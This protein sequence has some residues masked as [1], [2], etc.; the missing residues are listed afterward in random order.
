MDNL[1]GSD[2]TKGVV[3]KQVLTLAIPV[4]IGM[5]LTMGYGIINM[6]WIG[7]FLG[8]EA[9]AAASVGF[10]IILMLVSIASGSTMAVTVLVS[11]SYGNKN[12]DM[13]QKISGTALTFFSLVALVLT[14]AGLLFK[15]SIL[16]LM[17]TPENIFSGASDYLAF[18]LIGFLVTYV[19]SVFTAM[20]NGIGDTKTPSILLFISTGLNAV[21]DPLFIKIFGLNGA[22][23]ASLISG[24][25]CVTAAAIYLRKK[26]P[27]FN[28]KLASIKINLKVL[29]DILKIGVPSVIQDGLT[30]IAMIFITGIVNGFGTDATAAFGAASKV[31]YLII[32]PSIALLTAMSVY[33]GQNLGANKIERVKSAFKT[34]IIL[35]IGV[36]VVITSLVILLPEVFLKTMVQDENVL[37]IGC[38]YLRTIGLGYCLISIYHVSNGI[39]IGAGKSL[40]T[41][42]ISIISLIIIRI[43]LADFLSKDLLGLDGIWLACVISYAIMA[44]CSITYYFRGKW[45]D[46][47]TQSEKELKCRTQQVLGGNQNG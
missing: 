36:G 9:V 1:L 32:M 44:L 18:S 21:L 10:S 31:D 37:K 25:C 17:N 12:Y 6:I 39:L 43:P 5:I 33:T 38:T 40:I 2:L 45:S 28:L 11:K 35:S 29:K 20:L 42:A 27:I 3:H 23:I 13:V 47:Q 30:P 46:G 4:L 15:N 26:C 8:K 7:N 22:A 14:V 41:M 19:Y 34:G 16:K 24:I